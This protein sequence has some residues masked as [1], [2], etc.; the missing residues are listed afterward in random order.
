MIDYE[1][2][3]N[4]A[5]YAAATA[6]DGPVLVIAGAGSGKTRTI[7]YRM[8][9]LC[10]QG[11]E[12]H[13]MLLLTFT[14]K[15]AQEMMH[16]AGLLLDR[17]LTGVR[18]GTFH[19][20]AFA[21]LRQYRPSWLEGRNFSVMDTADMTS[22]L[23][24]CKDLHKIGKGDRS[25]P[26][27]QN[28]L[29]IFSKARNKE[30][31]VSEVI[32]KESAH[33]QTHIDALETLYTVYGDFRRAQ[34]LLDYDD[35]LFELETLLQENQPDVQA[36]RQRLRYIM[37]DEYQDTNKVQ[38]RLVRLLGATECGGCGNVMA[39][40][41]DAQSIYA[42]RGAYVRNILD[43]S[44][45]FPGA[46][47]VRLEENYRSTQPVLHVANCLLSHAAEHYDKNLFTTRE[48]GDPVRIV[49]PQSD[50]SQ[51]HMVV[52]RIE[53]LL[54][55][56][57]PHDI[58]VLF[59]ASFHSYNLEIALKHA[60]IP[61]RKFGGI[62]FAE[63]A[64]I[65]DALSYARLVVN[66]LDRQAFERIAL[67]HKGV[68]KK[69]VEKLHT[70][71]ITKPLN[72]L[73]KAFGK[74]TGLWE[75]VCFITAQRN[76]ILSPE[77]LMQAIVEHYVPHLTAQYPDDWPKRRQGLDEI[78]HM[79]ARHTNL[80]EFIAD[81]V[82]DPSETEQEGDMD[83]EKYIT[84]STIH[85]AK[86][87]EWGAVIIIDLV[88]ERF[89][90][91]HALENAETF[92]EERRLMYVA[93]TRA[94]SALDLYAPRSVYNRAFRTDELTTPSPFLRELP[95]DLYEEWY[96]SYGKVLQRRARPQAPKKAQSTRSPARNSHA[97]PSTTTS[98][99]FDA[100]F[101]DTSSGTDDASLTYCYHKIF[102]RGKIV[103][104][105]PP[106]KCQVNFQNFGLKV[107]LKEF[108]TMDGAAR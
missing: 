58:A 88:E 20:F 99:P 31:S 97:T 105:M 28:I 4:A 81:I 26:K 70:M 23:A 12:P 61:F 92:E 45:S 33:L 48:G 87:L 39:V 69:T 50:Q 51:A 106:D 103:R 84:L 24:H 86:G 80:D 79:A 108:L 54:E 40:G 41:D 91:R 94:R 34:C 100:A 11:V 56:H 17:G 89:P 43:F 1:K 2:S 5:Q 42:F 36:L 98:A 96:E 46:Q 10:E 32:H 63:A 72:E 25:F 76:L 30:L 77:S 49:L 107:I 29:S 102:G 19:A 53:E 62:R 82:L 83:K 52:R 57:V 65:K 67:L 74:H 18:G 104:M 44:Q 13:H 8:A 85:S 68:G 37:V 27:N 21:T 95:R 66:P 15:A 90:S 71:L 22:A 6:E 47:I 59:R 35:L 38:A 14:R 93:C 75:D 73:K 7:V 101:A 55:H 9:W 60:N 3:L 64:H 78:V 16:R